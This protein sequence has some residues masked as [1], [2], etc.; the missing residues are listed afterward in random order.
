MIDRIQDMISGFH[1][2]VQLLLPEILL[3][4]GATI[5]LL[6]GL[7]RNLS[8]SASSL[9]LLAVFFAIGA[10]VLQSGDSAAANEVTSLRNSEFV[11]YVRLITLA[12]TVLIL[13]VNRHVPADDVR[14]EYF[15]LILFSVAGVSLVA[16]ANNLIM[17]FLALE[18]V[19]VPTYIL[20]GL[21]RRDIH[22][23]ESA[24]KYFFL[25]AFA[26]AITLYGFSFLYGYAGTMTIFGPESIAAAFT[27]SGAQRDT[28]AM[29]GLL[30]SLGGLG[31]KVAA[32]PFHFYVADVYQGAA[33]PITGM[34]G[35]VPK[36]AGFAAIINV[37]GLTGWHLGD[38][39]FWLLWVLAVLTMTVGNTLALMQHNVKR[40]LAYSSVAHSGYMLV[41]LAAGPAITNVKGDP[42]RD[43]ISSL[44][45]Y[46]AAYGVMNLGCFAAFSYFRRAAED[47]PDES[48]ESLDDL[49]GAAREHPWATLGLSICVLGLMG[50]PLTAGFVGKFYI[51]SSALSST[52]SSI[53]TMGAAHAGPMLALVIILAL[54]AAV[55]AAYY[56]R[57]LAA[58][59]LRKPATGI[60]TARC[61]ALQFGMATC[62]LIVLGLFVKPVVLHR[63]SRSA[64]S[65]VSSLAKVQKAVAMSTDERPPAGDRSERSPLT[66]SDAE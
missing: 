23:Q 51:I 50:F 66:V 1:P 8:K 40:M 7:S 11:S 43:G 30:L 25:G 18:L 20:I 45:F 55:A 13:L 62:A 24:G 2:L 6:T 27:K 3:V 46:I 41:A 31:F 64:A 63:W 54:N 61:H 38:Q 35:F 42:L 10:T 32:V 57:I 5:I 33:S 36:F 4:L 60:T 48:V 53:T 15:S 21:S 14:A 56:L 16:I 49:A 28:L 52:G 34:L 39:I 26:A 59:Y 37:L 22:A 17:L 29:M 58:C 47:D 9:A 12:I 65:A 44:L 19:S